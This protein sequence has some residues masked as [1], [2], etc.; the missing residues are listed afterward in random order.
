MSCRYINIT[1]IVDHSNIIFQHIFIMQWKQTKE[2]EG[3]RKAVKQ[4]EEKEKYEYYLPICL[5]FLGSIDINVLIYW[6]WL[7]WLRWRCHRRRG[8]VHTCHNK[9]HT[10]CYFFS[11]SNHFQRVTSHLSNVWAF[12]QADTMQV[13]KA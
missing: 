2:E 8:P 5:W 12:V 3:K 11:A 10:F 7:R 1:T 9:I 13:T 6:W 4:R